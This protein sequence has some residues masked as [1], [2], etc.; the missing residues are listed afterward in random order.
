[1]AKRRKLT[2]VQLDRIRADLVER[3]NSLLVENR[4]HLEDV[5][6]DSVTGDEGDRATA[7]YSQGMAIQAVERDLQE[8]QSIEDALGRID[9][10]A[11]GACED[12]S[13]PIM[14]ARLRALPFV[15]TCITCQEVRE[16][17]GAPRRVSHAPS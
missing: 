11:Y 4:S 7:T 1:M 12:C 8:L 3:R 16:E 15:E 17:T 14:L 10:G 13:D 5:L 2:K 6:Q 9:A